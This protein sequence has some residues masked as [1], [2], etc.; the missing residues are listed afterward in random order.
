M[1]IPLDQVL[2][3]LSQAMAVERS[4]PVIFPGQDAPDSFRSDEM[5]AVVFN[6]MAASRR[7]SIGTP[8]LWQIDH[9]LTV[10]IYCP[11]QPAVSIKRARSLANLVER[12]WMAGTASGLWRANSVD[13]TE[14]VPAEG[15]YMI[16]IVANYRYHEEE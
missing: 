3:P 16:D 12:F 7:A 13:T 4:I 1:S 10:R 14:S 6:S 2:T 11:L 5:H 8:A 15:R 9:E